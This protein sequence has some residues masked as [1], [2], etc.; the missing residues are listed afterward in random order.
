[1]IRWTNNVNE[2]LKKRWYEGLTIKAICFEI[3]CSQASLKTQR[4]KLKLKSRHSPTTDGSYLK[5]RINSDLYVSASR[6]AFSRH[7]TLAEYV[8][9]LIR[10]DVGV[11]G[12]VV[13]HDKNE[14]S[15]IV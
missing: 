9:M 8:R 6:M 2:L 3:G 13:V 1:M 11:S 15:R 5:I 4:R 7:S 10:R 14:Q 12:N